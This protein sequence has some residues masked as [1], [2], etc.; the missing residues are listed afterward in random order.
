MAIPLKARRL[1]EKGLRLLDAGEI[2]QGFAA[3]DQ[4]A[5]LKPTLLADVHRNKAITY[6]RLGDYE[7]SLQF[8]MRALELDND[9]A[10]VWYQM[11]MCLFRFGK[12]DDALGAYRRAQRLGLRRG[13]LTHNILACELNIA[14]QVVKAQTTAQA[15]EHDPDTIREAPLGPLQD[16]QDGKTPEGKG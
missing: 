6:G 13:G 4:A 10:E 9:Y 11:G 7:S 3:L 12:Y 8:C 1:L 14:Q 16:A 15:S 5:A 2:S